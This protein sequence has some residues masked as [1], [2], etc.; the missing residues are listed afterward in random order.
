MARADC[1]V[2]QKK[3]RFAQKTVVKFE[4][5]DCGKTMVCA[6]RA[7]TRSRKRASK[8]WDV[9]RTESMAERL[10]RKREGI[11]MLRSP[12]K[13]W[14]M[15]PRSTRDSGW[16]HELAASSILHG[17]TSPPY[18]FFDCTKNEHPYF[19]PM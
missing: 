8:S 9:A 6:R 10:L 15:A 7:M 4:A 18:L 2:R 3:E 12:I 13:G 14:A 16:L 17:V 5:M 1:D 19:F 11:N